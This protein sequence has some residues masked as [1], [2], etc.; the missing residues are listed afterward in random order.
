MNLNTLSAEIIDLQPATAY[1]CSVYTINAAGMG[2][3]SKV[4]T[5]ITPVGPVTSLS[6]D[7]SCSMGVGTVTW[8][9][10]SGA[11]LYRASAVDSKGN[12]LSC[13]S[14]STECQITGLK[15]G[16]G[17]H[18]HVTAVSSNCESTA[19]TTT[20]FETVPC[21]PSDLALYRECSSNVIIITWE[22]T[23]HTDYY[24]ATAVDSTGKRTDCL[25]TEIACFFDQTVCGRLYEFTVYAVSGAC[26]GEV[27]TSVS[28][29]TAPCAATNLQTNADCN[30]DV[31]ISTWNTAPGALLYK[32]EAL[33][34][35]GNSTRYNCSTHTNSCAIPGV[36]CGESLTVRIISFDDE[37]SSETALGQVAE[38]VPCVPQNVSAVMD[39]S[40]NSVTMNWEYSHGAVFYIASAVHPDGSTHTCSAINTQCSIQ[41]LRCGQVYSAFIIATNLKCNSSEST[42]ITVETAPCPPDHIGAL[43]DCEANQALVSWQS[44][45][46]DA[47]Y[48]VTMEDKE[49]GL[50]SC[51]TA[52]SNCTIPDL[53]CGQEYAVTV[54]HHTQICPSRPSDAIHVH[55][56]PCGPENMQAMVDCGTGMLNISWEASA[57]AQSYTT[58]VS[59]ESRE[60]IYQ[61]STDPQ[62]SFHEL[63][64]G[65]S[66]TVMVKSF[67]G[68]CL[69]MPSKKLI[70]Q[71]PCVP[72]N[73]TVERSCGDS[74]VQVMWGASPGAKYYR[75]IARSY[76]GHNA[77][78]LSNE[79]SCGFADLHCG[80]VYTVG[81]M[82]VDDN[83]TSLQSQTVTLETV[84]C[85]PL[86]PAVSL[87]CTTNTAS[88]SWDTSPNA[89]LYQGRAVG[90]DGHMASCN[91]SSPGCQ[92]RGLRCGQEY[93][94][95]VSASDGSC[96]SPESAECTQLTAPCALQS[97]ET[98]LHCDSNILSISWNTSGSPLSYS[99]TA[100]LSDGT[101]HSC[102]SPGSSCDIDSLSCG[103]QYDVTVTASNNNCSGPAGTI[104]TIQTVPCVPQGLKREVECGTNTLT[105]SWSD[106]PGASLYTATV[107]GPGGYSET[108]STYELNCSFSSL[109]CAQEYSFSVVAHGQQCN[110]STSPAASTATGPCEPENIDIT[111]HCES[112]TM[113]VSWDSSAGADS[114][115]VLAQSEEEHLS[116]CRTADTFCQLSQLQCGETYNITVLAG[117]WL[118]NS[119]AKAY[120]VREA[121][122]CPP[123]IA[124]HT[125]DCDTNTASLSWESD[126][127][128]VGFVIN[129]TS[130]QGLQTSCST[131]NTTTTCELRDLQC[132]QTYTLYGTAQGKECDSAPGPG[133]N[134]ITVSWDDSLGRESFLAS[135]EGDGHTDS[136]NTTRTLCL[137][138]SLQC[139]K[140]YNVSVCAMT[141][142]CNSSQTMGDII[143]TAPCPPQN[144][145]ASLMCA[146]NTALIMWAPTGFAVAYNVT[147]L[148][149]DGDVKSC[150]TPDTSCE[151]PK[152][153]CG[154]EYAI[155]V[156][157]YTASCS[158]YPSEPIFYSA[159]PCPPNN[160][161]VALECAGNIGSVTWEAV[162]GAEMYVATAR[163]EDEH[164]HT[165]NSSSTGCSFT[166]L[167]CGET[168]S[169]TVVTFMRGCYSDPS[170][171]KTLEA[172]ICPPTNLE[173]DVSCST[174]I[175]MLR[176]DS[177]PVVGVKY[178]LVLEKEGGASTTHDTR[179]TSYFFPSMQCGEHYT[180]WVI[181]Q[182]STCNS[183]LSLPF[184]HDTA[185]CPPSNLETDVDCGTSSGIISWLPGMGAE[186]YLAEAVGDHGHRASCSAANSTSCSMKLDCGHHYSAT[187]LSSNNACNSTL[188]ATVEFDSAPCLPGNVSAHLHCSRNEFAVKWEGSLGLET[189]T[190]LAIG[191]DGYRASCNTSDTA[192]TVQ[193]LRCGLT[194][195]IAV[196]T[197]SVQCGEIRGSDY[198]VQS[199][200]CLPTNPTVSVDCW[201]SVVTVSWEDKMAE[202]MN[203][204]TAVDRLGQST[205]CNTTNSSC[206][207]EQLSC[208]E[209]YSFSVVG[210]TEQ[211][212]T[213]ISSTTEHLTAPCV[214]THV[215]A[216]LNC[217]T[218]IALVT[219]DSAQGATSYSVEAL[220][221]QGHSTSHLSSDTQFSI[222]DLQCGQEYNITV[223]GVHEGCQGLPSETVVIVTGPCPLTDLD[224][225]RDC[226]SNSVAIS[227]TPGRGTL[228]YNAS[229]ESFT[230]G[231]Y[232][233]CTTNSSACDVSSLQ[234]GERYRVSVEGEGRTCVSPAESWVPI[235]TAPCPPQQ[236]SM[237]TSCDSD[238]VDV[239]WETAKGAVRYM[240][241]AE[242]GQ[243]NVLMCNTSDTACRITGLSCGRSY[244]VSVTALDDECTGG[245]SKS[246]A[247]K[248]APCVPLELDTTLDCQTGL[249]SVVWQHS[250]GAL[251]YHAMVKNSSGQITALAEVNS[252]DFLFT[253]PC[254]DTYNI[255]VHASDVACSSSHSPAKLVTAAPCPPPSIT[256]AVDCSSNVSSVS[257]DSSA[258]GV[259]Y[260]VKATEASGHYAACNTTGSNCTLSGLHCGT[261]YNLTVFGSLDSCTGANTSEYAI[262]TAPCKPVLTEVEMDCL[263]DSAWVVWEESVGA[264]VYIATAVDSEDRVFQCNSSENTCAVPDLLCGQHYTFTVA[265]SD[266]QCV[267]EPSN[268]VISES[269][270]CPPQD[271]LATMGCENRT[272]SIA[273][274]ESY[275]ALT[276]TA[277]LER[278]DGD[279]SCCTTSGT[280][281]DIADLPCGEMY[282]LMVSAEGHTCNSSLSAGSIIRTVP[283]TPE[284]LA[285]NVSCSNNVA[286]AT[287]NSS[288][289]GQLYIVNAYGSDGHSTFCNSFD[290][291]C[292]LSSLQCGQNYTITVV[293][294]DSTCTSAESL[295]A[296]LKTVPCVPQ[297]VSTHIDCES[298]SMSISWE[299]SEGADSYIATLEDRDGLATDCQVLG[300]NS[301]NVSGLSCGRTYRATVMASDGYCT[302][303]ESLA[304]DAQSVPCPTSHLQAV[305]DC[306]SQTALV[307][308]Y[309][310]TGA[311][312]YTATMETESGHAVACNTNLTNCAMNE[313]ACGEQYSL[314]VLAEGETC[315]RLENMT[316][317]IQTEPCVPL[318]VEV[319]YNQPIGL[320]N[321][322]MSKGA[323]YYSAE[324]IT[325]RGELVT[326]NTTDT[327][328][329]LHNMACSMTFNISVTAHN[330]ACRDIATSDPITLVTEPCAPQHVEANVNCDTGRVSVSWELSECAVGY[331]VLL[332]GRDGHSASCDT[333]NTFC[334]VEA[335]HCGTA[336]VIQVRAIGEQFNSSDTS[337]IVL[338][339]APCAPDRVE[340]E[341]GCENDSALV[342]WSFSDGATSYAVA[343]IGVNGHRAH[344]STEGNFCTVTGL[345]CGETYNLSLTSTNEQCD[346]LSHTGQTFQ[347]RPCALQRLAVDLE[348]GNSTAL[349]S[350]E[351]SEGVELYVANATKSSG[352]YAASCNST[353]STCPF[354]HLECGETYTF[355]VT[356]YS[357][358]CQ[359]PLSD[360]VEITTGPCPPSS[361]SASGLC[362]NGTVLLSWEESRGVYVYIITAVGDLGYVTDFNTTDTNLEMW[363]PCGQTYS[364]SVVAWGEQCES[365]RSQQAEVTTAPCA[366]QH[367]RAYVFCE[368]STGSV[369]WGESDG[370]ESYTAVAVGQDS[371]THMCFTKTTSCTWDDLHCG[372]IYTV[373]VIANYYLCN[374][375]PSNATTIFMAPCVP[376]NLVPSLD[377]DM[378]VGILTWDASETAG[379]YI[380]AA[381]AS[382]SHRM[383]VTTNTTKAMISEFA[384]GEVYYLT[385]SAVGELCISAPSAAVSLQTE[386]CPPTKV[387]AELDCFTNNILVTWAQSEGAEY[388]SAT[389]QAENGHTALCMSD[390]LQCGIASLLCAQNYSVS[391]TA[392]NSE[393]SSD[394]S[395]DIYLLSAPCIPENVSVLMDC[396]ENTVL[397]SWS[398]SQGALS[399]KVVAESAGGNSSCTSSMPHCRLTNLT[400]GTNYTVWVV[401]IDD[402]C[403]T[404]HSE[405]VQFQS[406]PCTPEVSAVRLDCY[407]NSV[408]V[409]WGYAEG[410]TFYTGVAESRDYMAGCSTNHTNCEIMGLEC[411]QAYTVRVAA[412]NGICNSTLSSGWEVESVP[413]APQSVEYRLD[414]DSHSAR[415]MWEAGDGAESYTVHAYGWGGHF[416]ECNTTGLAC[417]VPDLMCSYSYNISVVSIN[418]QC[419][420]SKSNMT[421]MQAVPCVPRLVEANVDCESAVVSVSWEQSMGATS[422]AVVAQ[423][424]GGYV[425]SCN[426]SSTFC[427][428]SDLLCGTSYSVTVSAADDACSSEPSSPVLV[429]TVPC[430]PQNVSSAVDCGSSVGMVWWELGEG[431][432]SYH[433][434]A[435]G[436]DGHLTQCNSSAS[437]CQL[438]D[439]HCGQRYNLSV[440]AQDRQCDT[441]RAYL[442]LQ[443]VPCAPH[444]VQV[445][446]Q[447]PYSFASITWERGS[448]ALSYQAMG[449]ATNKHLT[450]CNSSATYCDLEELQCGQTYNVSVLSVNDDC[451]TAE[452]ASWQVQ[453]APCPPI[454]LDAWME[455]ETG[456]IMAMWD[457]NEDADSFRVEAQSNDGLVLSCDT[458]DT[459][460]AITNVLCGHT[461][462]VSAVSIR[463]GCE[464]I[465][466]AADNLTAAPCVPEDISRN[467]DCVTNSAWVSW[468]AALGAH[469]Y[470]VIAEGVGGY[471]ASCST[472][473]TTC[474]V[475][476][477][478]CGVLYTFHLIAINSHCH[479][480]P[481]A[482]FQIETAPCALTTIHAFTEC[483]SSIIRVAWELSGGSPFY[484]A[485]AEGHDRSVLSCNSTSAS[486]NLTEAQCGI[487]YT[488]I[489]ATSSDKCSSLRSP[490][491]KISTAPCAPDNVTFE[492]DCESE[493]V[494]VS[495]APSFV[496]DSYLLTAEGRNGDVHTCN[497]T[498]NNCTL[499]QL[500]CGQHYSLTV[501]ASSESC[502]SPDSAELSFSTAPCDPDNL[503][504][505]LQCASSSAVLSWNAS[506]G[507]VEYFACAQGSTGDMLYCSGRDTSCIIE[508]LECGAMYNFSVQSSDGL[509]N[510]SFSE[511]LLQG[512]VPCSPEAVKA[513]MLPVSDDDKV[514]RVSWSEVL[515]PEVEYQVEVAGC[516]LGDSEALFEVSSYWTERTFFEIPL[517]C[518]SM[519][520]M[521]VKSRNSAGMS[522][523]SEV[524][525]RPTVSCPPSNVNLTEGPAFAILSWSASVYASY[526]TVYELSSAGKVEACN[527]TQLFCEV[528]LISSEFEITA[529]NSAGE[530]SPASVHQNTASKRR[531]RNLREVEI[532]VGK[533]ENDYLSGPRISISERTRESLRVEWT[534]VSEATYYTLIVSDPA[535]EL[536][537]HNH[538]S[539]VEPVSQEAYTVTGLEPDT[540]YCVSV[541]AMNAF[542]SSPYSNV[543]DKTLKSS[544]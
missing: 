12:I 33:G 319:Q 430:D 476:D 484:I 147:A 298:N 190:A 378:K 58:Y 497:N 20:Y 362:S 214:P 97:M 535:G 488:I 168:Y 261:A 49:G 400:C 489:V 198:M 271:I 434:Q 8:A 315:S 534:A 176:W 414:C 341:V 471:N 348:C 115:V 542:A 87:D 492:A 368:N 37:C 151:L 439:L 429:D 516:I 505:E 395:H 543:C 290:T 407:V 325:E 126:D 314:S 140:L 144:V 537:Y 102:S 317:T 101:A 446:L 273:W 397:V 287:W 257:W 517:P 455:C 162:I 502:T 114:Y 46:S 254:G 387:S 416:S 141:N 123:V 286:T 487:Q 500:H 17:Y 239:S 202:Q 70:T 194:Y 90:T 218:G 150:Q 390:E 496:A 79:T 463:D 457:P 361:L 230:A 75:A 445:S 116:S 41:G 96:Q 355:T 519:Y 274:A 104:Q 159:G 411:G 189:Y 462:T 138:S 353:G 441:S 158:G 19:N 213:D 528:S 272:A 95:T 447:C 469:N 237:Q 134:I 247:V 51:M 437:S 60:W 328:C 331:H 146:N 392:S 29:K 171:V 340:V 105:A 460:C 288:N 91:S 160:V 452:S 103:Q 7:Y 120:A 515:C 221:S 143:Q 210:L 398:H 530:S 357:S 305:M 212:Q 495:W 72:A 188:E 181:T 129:G 518:S 234:C 506:E 184:E 163:A 359:S 113:L 265:A 294:E 107:S 40:P 360:T 295:P 486:C 99:A 63:D 513:R 303:P 54:T 56:V 182:D 109:L 539:V 148:G 77:Q 413:C 207:F 293:A 349:L 18:V 224:A 248:T 223:A 172:A 84:P 226:A 232:L 532:L 216:D 255:T 6:V 501:T 133:V 240:A 306:R 92:I 423:G 196:T 69:S 302:S 346:G 536:T 364:F 490:P 67:N 383:E 251:L 270:P 436:E 178:F 47:S 308:W 372:D 197:S 419:N 175:L 246:H 370:A 85:P 309:F 538:S 459:F 417:V 125:V 493:G 167:H 351:E 74:S 425:P 268:A 57:H 83:C 345:I 322:D 238:T 456:I 435:A 122:P 111:P 149:Q 508:G 404:I 498:Q 108:C 43:L 259:V 275:L 48:T 300:A 477:L 13:S 38:T 11:D 531:K 473:S 256:T 374:S 470:M 318:N 394:P 499:E 422:Y 260:T 382:N 135:V 192:C 474:N 354:H 110:S 229:V 266:W 169:I 250:D 244:N 475:P 426:T 81:V 68:S 258:H 16:E 527:T 465:H 282:V 301:C 174:N 241:A 131:T 284:N 130:T 88:L 73:V 211:C 222:T 39:C 277:T 525:T 249:L 78:C 201:T 464:S 231:H 482:T 529:S 276:Y 333:T 424:T 269:A 399:Y 514:L 296:K 281:C 320:L 373:H 89:V 208:G 386:P 119:S 342:S 526:Y 62:C 494:A 139:G 433:V 227:W 35:A 321:W 297:N 376:Q 371:H 385:V 405:R 205:T 215:A 206:I 170:A 329:A 5:V 117:D 431:A 3:S 157:P 358:Q 179:D 336:Y 280:S 14:E 283:C 264:E 523:P 285:A 339:M 193:G 142:H 166:D 61:E 332:E 100:S 503:E 242:D 330:Q 409:E 173:E 10:V 80:E 427:E 440:T 311:L 347:T 4:I 32:V 137:F 310:S 343:V 448:G 304:T 408:L 541:A 156:T 64:C 55:S 106:S 278:T 323:T 420:I 253:L 45:L 291:S 152:M 36:H 481:S 59:S 154:Q 509:C 136:C 483:H 366:P 480:L 478:Q 34:N 334:S 180:L 145:S 451:A 453:A 442:S 98:H 544:S 204:V 252:T 220:G 524:I 209:T 415:V 327:N 410:A 53:K 161:G 245:R 71:V 428:F 236:V 52:D 124:H 28:I 93:T 195:S 1:D 66:Y 26:E 472:H 384:C 367:V 443:S 262:Q 233:I 412:S 402:S 186:S 466:S 479:S 316:G 15:C 24:V 199:A 485:T 65:R 187:V 292:D 381:E 313:L 82:A 507:A 363:L 165:C 225:S 444:N 391:V 76:S 401:A 185:P 9:L 121:A 50:L 289:G 164:E 112:N 228:L 263:S 338:I 449:K 356:A 155:T 393:C 388:Y 25:T 350:W 403:S 352:E 44:H 365:P 235:N 267:G 299:L 335:L 450:T 421:E 458:Q 491:R 511:P 540:E 418:H 30:S 510:S 183:S 521:T 127:D 522:Q 467:L 128:M 279:I 31:L 94:F 312:S 153:H 118:C 324:A 217:G 375:D 380:V 326:C 438:P 219:W 337:N 200:P 307:S 2:A 21:A 27:S 504:V 520:N 177:S 191:R 432:A 389:V 344:C 22:P 406:V 23:N 454:N 243:G 533:E 203:I 42:H 468:R 377:C 512:A 461:Y 379:L 369:S 396:T 86:H 132:G